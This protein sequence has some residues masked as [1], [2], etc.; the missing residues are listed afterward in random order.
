MSLLATRSAV[1]LLMRTL[2]FTNT[3]E[4]TAD[5]LTVK[6]PNCTAPRSNSICA[7]HRLSRDCS[8][9]GGGTAFFLFFLRSFLRKERPALSVYHIVS[10][11]PTIRNSSCRDCCSMVLYCRF[12]KDISLS[13]IDKQLIYDVSA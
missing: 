4:L 10:F 6:F 12:V 5:S 8:F 9:M 1:G 7:S 13:R 3:G 11:T 2:G